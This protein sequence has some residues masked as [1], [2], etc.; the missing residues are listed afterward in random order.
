L[1]KPIIL[2]TQ[3]VEIGR[4]AVQSQPGSK[5]KFARA[6]SQPMAG[7]DGTHLLSQLHREGQVGP[8]KV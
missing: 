1:L 2:A 4:M 8:V 5:K 6:S 3:E 7:H